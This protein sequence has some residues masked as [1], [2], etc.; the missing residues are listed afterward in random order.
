MI[1]LLKFDDD[2]A[3]SSWF[4]MMGVVKVISFVCYTEDNELRFALQVDFPEYPKQNDSILISVA[5]NT[6]LRSEK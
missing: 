4:R 1:K 2:C 5:G 6:I 3:L